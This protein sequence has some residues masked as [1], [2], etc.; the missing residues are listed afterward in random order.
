MALKAFGQ[1][2]TVNIV[3]GTCRVA[4]KSN[5]LEEG[6][7]TF[8]V[9]GD[10]LQAGLTLEAQRPLGGAHPYRSWLYMETQQIQYL[11]HGARAVCG[12]AG[13]QNQ[14]LDRPVYECVMGMEE[15]PI[16]VHPNFQTLAG[17][18]SAPTNGALFLDP[19]T[20][21]I[22]TNDL[23]GIFDR[24]RPF[25]KSGGSTVKNPKAGIE[26]FLDPVATY[27][28][29]FVS[30]SLP[31]AS[32]FGTVVT[33][34]PGPGLPG[35]LGRRNFLYLG[36]TWRRRGDPNGIQSRVLYE[37]NKEWRAS[38]RNGWDTDVYAT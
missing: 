1:T 4:R 19:E 32:G 31:S 15:S 20:G 17:K 21:S 3:A 7:C 18:P 38:G 5:G 29:S 9:V 23:R 2:Y 26:A 27:R 25:V 8:E 14:Y 10:P 16:E 35:V 22:T 33:S 13:V 24:F 11:P 34:L 6:E 12:Y 30:L 37:V 36:Y 28:E